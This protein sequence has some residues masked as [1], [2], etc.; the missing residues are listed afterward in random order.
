MLFGLSM[1]QLSESAAKAYLTGPPWKHT[2][3]VTTHTALTCQAIRSCRIVNDADGRY[4]LSIYSI[5]NFLNATPSDD[6]HTILPK[7]RFAPSTW[8]G[9]SLDFT[10][11]HQN[12]YGN[13]HRHCNRHCGGAQQYRMACQYYASATALQLA[14]LQPQLALSGHTSP[15]RRTSNRGGS[16]NEAVPPQDAPAPKR[17]RDYLMHVQLP[18]SCRSGGCIDA[19]S[20]QARETAAS[21]LSR[22]KMKACAA[23]GQGSTPTIPTHLIRAPTDGLMFHER[24]AVATPFLRERR[25]FY[26]LGFKCLDWQPSAVLDFPHP[27]QSPALGRFW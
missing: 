3:T 22:L 21:A 15:D 16:G 7:T 19:M 6:R 14:R 10:A 4:L 26:P 9:R 5:K 23:V 18:F 20:P 2:M 27:D 24:L 13:W 25:P 12:G 17:P 11:R 8:Q 1:V